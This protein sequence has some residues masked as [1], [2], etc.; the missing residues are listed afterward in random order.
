[1]RHV[2]V[3]RTPQQ[4]RECWLFQMNGQLAEVWVDLMEDQVTLDVG[5]LAPGIYLLEVHEGDQRLGVAKVWIQ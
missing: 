2:E 4:A 5:H 3:G 1:M